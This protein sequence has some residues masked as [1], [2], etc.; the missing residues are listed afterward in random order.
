MI[1]GRSILRCNLFLISMVGSLVHV[2]I[3]LDLK[4]VISSG[5]SYTKTCIA[6]TRAFIL[7]Y[8]ILMSYSLPHSIS[9]RKNSYLV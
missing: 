8:F 1:V 3:I 4:N 7:F 6:Y 2:F 5:A 9:S